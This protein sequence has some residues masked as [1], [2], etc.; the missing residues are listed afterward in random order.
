MEPLDTHY[1]FTNYEIHAF[2]VDI[3]HHQFISLRVKTI[4]GAIM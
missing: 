1:K 3:L 4:F 2:V